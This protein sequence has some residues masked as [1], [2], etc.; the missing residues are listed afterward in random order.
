MSERAFWLAVL[1]RIAAPVLTN[2]A[3]RQL[4]VKMPVEA[5]PHKVDERA[6]FTHLEALGRLLCGIAPWLSLSGLSG[7]EETLR[8]RYAKLAQEALDAATDPASPDFMNFGRIGRQPLVD[9]AF[10]GQA[11]LRAPDI[12]WRNLPARVQDNLISALEMSRNCQPYFCNW[13]MFSAMVEAALKECGRPWDRVR[14]DYALRQHEQW[15]LGDGI[16]GDGPQFHWDYYNSFVIQPMLLD[17]LRVVG[18]EDPT[19]AA[20]K[21]PVLTRA[22]RYAVILERFISPE[23][24]FPPIGRSIT[25][26]FGSL[27]L[28]AY[29]A[30]MHELPSEISPAQVRCA[31]GAVIR[32]MIDAPGTF[33]EHGWLTIGFCGH[34]PNLGEGYISTGSLYLCATALLP[35]G[36]TPA[37]PF[38]AD[39]PCDWTAKRI[40]K[41]ENLPADHAI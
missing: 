3:A 9:V 30:L 5:Q 10:L 35:L 36:L 15:Y 40:W 31:M 7:E 1:E 24:T 33:D 37:D 22:R 26:R 16:Y 2:L 29:M 14:V 17:V 41:G 19:W 13:L 38:W 8:Q 39:P 32:R 18:D 20:M 25:Y 11:L 12:L 28:L 6:Q 21:E 27:H 34:Q 4:K 23:G